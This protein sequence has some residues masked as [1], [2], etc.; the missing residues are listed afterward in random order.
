MCVKMCNA[1]HEPK[2]QPGRN[3]ITLYFFQAQALRGRKRM[4]LWQLVR[5]HPGGS[6]GQFIT[7]GITCPNAFL[8]YVLQRWF[9]VER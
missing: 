4:G 5:I 6:F 8:G 3:L 7:I 2:N 1:L 9:C